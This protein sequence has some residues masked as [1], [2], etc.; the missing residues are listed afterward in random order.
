VTVWV[1]LQL[2]V[3]V[4]LS[5]FDD[6]NNQV[7]GGTGTPCSLGNNLHIVAVM[8]NI[9]PPFADLTEGTVYRYD[10][11]FGF[12]D[13][14]STPLAVATAPASL[15]YPPFTLPSF[16]L[17][18]TDLNLLRL[19]QGSCRMPRADGNDTRPGV[20]SRVV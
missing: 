20:P 18:P 8:A 11:A 3:P 9:L 6:K 12:A 15:A 16:A 7:M 1:A 13:S 4:T 10:L 19:L 5:V 14:G 2:G 17:P